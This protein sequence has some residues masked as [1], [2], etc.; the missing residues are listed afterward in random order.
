[1]RRRW[2]QGCSRTPEASSTTTRGPRKPGP[3]RVRDRCIGGGPVT[4]K[5]EGPGIGAFVV[6]AWERR[7]RSAS[8]LPLLGCRASRSGDCIRR[9]RGSQAACGLSP[10]GLPVNLEYSE[11]GVDSASHLNP[12]VPR[13]SHRGGLAPSPALP[14]DLFYPVSERFRGPSGAIE[15]DRWIRSTRRPPRPRRS[16]RYV[17]QEAVGGGARIEGL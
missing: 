5:A 8:L 4:D 11:Q 2:C 6:G 17:E 9:V 12:P 15:M 7:S 16:L 3:S 14:M 10:A 13:A 1:M